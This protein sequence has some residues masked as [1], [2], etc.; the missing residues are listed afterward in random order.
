MNFKMLGTDYGGWLIDLSLVP[1]E[2]VIIS[3]G[4]G[5]DIS[6]DLELITRKKCNVVGI[7]PTVKSHRFID[8][9]VDL[10]NFTLL[11]KALTSKNDDLIEIY[12]NKNP[13][14]VSE[15]ILPNHRAVKGFDYYLADT[16]NLPFLFE[17]YNNVS[18]IKLDI[19]G[20]EYE[21]INELEFMPDSVKQICIEFHHFC[22]EKTLEDTKKC[23]QKL[24]SLGFKDYVEKDS[25]HTLSEITFWKK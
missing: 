2:S 18:L 4:V 25:H 5:E 3:A 6:F 9:H 16:V 11:K 12:K 17:K 10:K 22:S 8:K 23:I 14:H 21:V 20:S 15:S 1:P 24:E 19:E 13:D 7:D